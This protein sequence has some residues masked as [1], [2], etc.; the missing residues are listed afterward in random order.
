[1]SD[2]LFVT[3][4]DFLLETLLHSHI[5]VANFGSTTILLLGEMLDKTLKVRQKF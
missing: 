3:M 1:M 4:F 5:L 2:R